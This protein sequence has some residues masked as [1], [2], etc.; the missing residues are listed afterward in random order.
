MPYKN[1]EAQL[2]YWREYSARP[3]TR[4]RRIVSGR[5][6][7]VAKCYRSTEH[8]RSVKAALQA[9][10]RAHFVGRMSPAIH[11]IYAR[12]TE[13]RQW[14]DV[15]VDHIVPLSKGGLHLPENLQLIYR[16][17]NNRKHNSDSYQP[18]VVFI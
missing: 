16:S 6:A 3:S 8:G 12:A 1:R 9:K 10:R 7:A 18:T 4:Q 17:E 14:F 11:K 5:N 15:V 13:L 2:S